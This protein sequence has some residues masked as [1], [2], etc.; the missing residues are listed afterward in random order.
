MPRRRPRPTPVDSDAAPAA[1]APPAYAIIDVDVH[2]TAGFEEYVAGHAATVAQYGG[3]LLVAGGR[4]EIIEGEWVPR[5]L[6]VH[7]WPSA[8]AF[9]RWYASED[10]RPWKMLRQRVASASVV[11]VEGDA[12][13]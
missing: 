4:R 13:A 5:R 7:R 8:E 6:V 9:K 12:D 3:T 2:D 1:A 10:Y 11:L